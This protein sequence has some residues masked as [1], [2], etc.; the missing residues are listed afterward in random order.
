MSEEFKAV[1][2]QVEYCGSWGYYGRFLTLKEAL[3]KACNNIEVS[4]FEGRPSS[5]EVLIG[6]KV[7]FSKL[8]TYG[9]PYEKDIIAAIEQS[10]IGKEPSTIENS[11]MT[12]NIL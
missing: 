8:Q 4:G 7:V 1:K 12:C 11:Q 9:F 10:R 2:V 3:E 6:G 5:F